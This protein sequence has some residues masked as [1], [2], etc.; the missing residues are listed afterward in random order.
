MPPP[1]VELADVLPWA[2]PITPSDFSASVI[3][4]S[5]DTYP[6]GISIP[7]IVVP[8][9]SGNVTDINSIIDYGYASQ[10]V[11]FSS[12]GGGV[13]AIGQ[14]A[15]GQLTGI[16]SPNVVI[17]MTGV[18]NYAVTLVDIAGKAIQRSPRQIFLKN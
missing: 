2:T 9:F 8:P 15:T 11:I 6:G 16:S 10:G 5:F 13:T 17:G 3:T 18:L 12:T 14:D 7:G 4:I 1:S